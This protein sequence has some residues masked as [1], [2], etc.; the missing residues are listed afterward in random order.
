VSLSNETIPANLG[1]TLDSLLAASPSE[2][3]RSIYRMEDAIRGLSSHEADARSMTSGDPQQN[4]VIITKDENMVVIAIETADRSGLLLDLSKCLARLQLELH[5]TEAAIKQGRSLSIWRCESTNLSEDFQ[6]EIW[7]V[8]QA[9]LAVDKGAEAVKRRG[10]RVLRA[11]VLKGR[12]VGSTASQLNFRETYKAAIVA[13]QRDGE[14]FGAESLSTVTFAEGDVIVLQVSDDSPLLQSPPE[15]F[16]DK[17]GAVDGESEGRSLGLASRMFNVRRGPSVPTG[18]DAAGENL[19]T[20][21]MGQVENND[22]TKAQLAVWKD[23][24]VLQNGV[25]SSGALASRE[26]LTAMK[27]VESSKLEGKSAA[28]AGIDKLPE[29]LLVSLERKV[30]LPDAGE[31][32]SFTTI[33]L[34]EPLKAGDVL[35]FSGTPSSVGE[36]RKIPGLISNEYEEVNKLSGKIFDRRL[37]QAVVA[38]EGNLVGKTIK[39]VRFRTLYGAAVISVHREGKRV[40]DHPGNIKL[41]SGDVLLLEAGPSFMSKKV[42]QDRSFA[43]VAEVEGSAPPR[44]RMLIPALILTFGAYG[45]YMAKLSTLIGSAMVAAILMVVL[46]IMS[47]SEARNA[48]RWDIYLTIASAFGI[49]KALVNSGVAGAVAK[50]LVKVGSAVGMGDAGLLGAVY[51]STVLISQVVANNAAAALIFPIAMEAAQTAGID[52][53]L[54]SF[55]IMLAASAAFM[56]PFGYQTNLMVMGKCYN[57]VP[58]SCFEVLL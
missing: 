40:H 46:G 49:G 27:V 58:S 44:M 43:L 48:I 34:S 13:V 51:L 5:H 20:A 39:E 52:L 1:H 26:F 29:L 47:E 33:A 17:Q 21:E 6:A 57:F 14:S 56:T 8:L 50:F 4:R 41:H 31:V 28:Q 2:R 54:M 32:T 15:S 11:R 53:L 35:W 22:A 7:T 25:N 23:L 18:V 38:R 3:M 12:L 9:L 30:P 45:C 37:V 36:L 24:K 42:Q 16:Y 10:L 55:T 19:G